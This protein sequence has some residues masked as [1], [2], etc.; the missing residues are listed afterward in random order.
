MAFV[1]F[2]IGIVDLHYDETL[3]IRSFIVSGI[4]LKE[5]FGLISENFDSVK[6]AYPLIN[7]KTVITVVLI[8]EGSEIL[9]KWA[10]QNNACVWKIKWEKVF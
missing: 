2:H 8:S 3:L 7:Y 4:V 1:G 5:H 10:D 9:E 6:G